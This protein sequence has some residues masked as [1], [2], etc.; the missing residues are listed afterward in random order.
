MTLRIGSFSR[1][2]HPSIHMVCQLSGPSRF[3]CFLTCASTDL[4]S[5]SSRGPNTVV[6]P[7]ETRTHPQTTRHHHHNNKASTWGLPSEHAEKLDP[8]WVLDEGR[9]LVRAEAGLRILSL[10]LFVG[11]KLRWALCVFIASSSFSSSSFSSE[12]LRR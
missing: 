5:L 11:E 7:A 10:Q 8:L 1:V 2:D 4:C 3:R 6:V 9:C 12:V